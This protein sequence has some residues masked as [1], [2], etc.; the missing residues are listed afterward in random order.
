MEKRFFLITG[1]SRG[2][3]NALAQTLLENGDT[4]LGVAR[5]NT[6]ALKFPKYHFLSYDLAD[7]SHFAQVME[8]M[9]EVVSECN[10]D[11]ICLVNNAAAIEPLGPIEKCPVDEIE[12][13][14]RVS[15]IAPM[16]LSS[17]FINRFCD[18]KARK[19]I[20]FISSGSAFTPLQHES[21]YGS[22]KAGLNMFAQC[23]GLEQ[24]DKEN[25]FEVIS[26][27]PGMVETAMQQVAR[28]KNRNE[29]AWVDL[30]QQFYE[31]GELDQPEKVA[32]KIN[33][34]LNNKYEQGVY[35]KAYE[36]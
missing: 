4:V 10:F 14:V 12:T 36:V 25:G 29:Y 7:T 5:G 13:H 26:I 35:I 1:T 33:L 15:L 31:N 3:G 32:E 16:V 28:S 2:L 11:F 27:G 30:A 9:D 6:A 34:I 23:I 17:L 22:S 8:K 21:I 24:K 18:Y 20:A 19:K